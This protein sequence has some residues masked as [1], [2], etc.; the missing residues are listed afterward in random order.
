[1]YRTN[2]VLWVQ[3]CMKN[4]EKTFIIYTRH[5]MA[6]ILWRY[7]WTSPRWCTHFVLLSSPRRNI[8]IWESWRL[9]LSGLHMVGSSNG[10]Q[11]SHW[12]TQI[13]H[14]YFQITHWITL[15]NIQICSSLI[16]PNDTCIATQICYKSLIHPI[17]TLL[18]QILIDP[19]Q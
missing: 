5:I 6:N 7:L 14:W 12:F 10:A 19:C 1:M 15:W 17:N 8:W 4:A 11:N 16:Y 18:S 2:M 13:T 3:K 9:G